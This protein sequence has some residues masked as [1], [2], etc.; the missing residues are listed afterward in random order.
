MSRPLAHTGAGLLVI[1]CTTNIQRVILAQVERE[2]VL[3]L[4]ADISS[5]SKGHT[6]Y[7]LQLT[8]PDMGFLSL[9][10]RKKNKK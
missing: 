6:Y 7:I 1:Q 10:E 4:V 9:S 5:N 3:D 8:D 2:T